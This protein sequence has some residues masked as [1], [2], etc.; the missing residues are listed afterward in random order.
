MTTKNTS[1]S[2]SP[3]RIPASAHTGTLTARLSGVK[4]WSRTLGLFLIGLPGGASF[5]M[6]HA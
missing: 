3:S 5:A 1:P 6:R 2:A 4:R